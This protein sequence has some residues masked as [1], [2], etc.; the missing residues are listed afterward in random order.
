MRPILLA[1]RSRRITALTLVA[2]ALLV[3][4]PASAHAQIGALARKAAAKAAR[5]AA[6]VSGIGA[7][8]PTFDDRVLELTDERVMAVVDGVH[9]AAAA[10]APD[11]STRAQLI[12][13]AGAANEQRN[14]L[15]ENRDDDLRRHDEETRRVNLC[16]QSILDSLNTVH[17]EAMARKAQALAASADPMGS[18]LMQDVMQATMESQRRMAAGDTAGAIA[19]Q[20]ALLKRQGIDPARDS[21]VASARCGKVPAKARWQLQADSLL[22]VAN[23]AMRLA[24]DIDQ[25]SVS[26]G[27]T[28][29]RMTTAQF[30]IARERIQAFASSN[31]NPTASWRF[32]PA[33]RKVLLARLSQLKAIA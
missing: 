15:L 27:A 1:F 12:S 18:K 30:A 2:V 10:T 33:E 24:Q 5:Q 16:A 9:A 29:A 8:S 25:R 19:V 31:G 3:A 14:A 23:T 6:G 7:E 21:T 28:V 32:S 11:G 26:T 22:E 4:A 20:R 13:R 17:N